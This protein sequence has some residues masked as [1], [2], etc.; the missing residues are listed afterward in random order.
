MYSGPVVEMRL[1]DQDRVVK[2]GAPGSF[3]VYS[4]YICFSQLLLFQFS[5]GFSLHESGWKWYSLFEG[6][7]FA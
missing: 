1:H 5:P 2:W 3:S 6:V 7:K 4:S